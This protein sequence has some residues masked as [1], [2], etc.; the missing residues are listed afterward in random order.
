MIST[1]CREGANEAKKGKKGGG[2]PALLR[3]PWV[4]SLL[5]LPP[6][7]CSRVRARRCLLWFAL[8]ALTSIAMGVP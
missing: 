4:T 6:H 8:A 5:S 3:L 1:H 7:G 2:V